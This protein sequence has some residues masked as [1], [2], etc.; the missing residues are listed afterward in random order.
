MICPRRT[1]QRPR[2]FDAALGGALEA[3]LGASP[4]DDLLPF[5]EPQARF[6][7]PECLP[8]VREPGVELLDLGLRGQV[9]PPRE[10]V[11]ELLPLFRELLDLDMDL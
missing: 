5:A 11:P 2:C 9:E 8:E 1:F 4:A 3:L 6:L 10:A 7:D